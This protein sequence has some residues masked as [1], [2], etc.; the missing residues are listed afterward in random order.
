MHMV[1]VPALEPKKRY[2]ASRPVRRKRTV[3]FADP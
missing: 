1:T 2:G 3:V